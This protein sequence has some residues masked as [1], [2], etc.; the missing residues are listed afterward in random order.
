MVASSRPAVEC[1]R[2]IMIYGS[3]DDIEVILSNG[4]D[5]SS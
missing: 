2:K 5:A 3:C 4:L 1:F